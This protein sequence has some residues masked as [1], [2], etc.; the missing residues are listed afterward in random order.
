MSI[1]RTV[2]ISG[3]GRYKKEKLPEIVYFYD[4]GVH[5]LEFCYNLHESH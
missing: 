4:M 2:F 3:G 5:C 1:F